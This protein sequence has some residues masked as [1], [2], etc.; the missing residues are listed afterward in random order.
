VT[1]EMTPEQMRAAIDAR[2]ELDILR[3]AQAAPAE[4]KQEKLN[5]VAPQIREKAADAAA[6]GAPEKNVEKK[7]KKDLLAADPQLSAAVLLLKLQLAG[8]E[9]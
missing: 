1:V 5:D 3:D 4:G 8:A 7:P 2:Q 9:L 6:G